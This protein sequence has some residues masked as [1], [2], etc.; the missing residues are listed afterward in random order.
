MD[1]TQLEECVSSPSS[2]QSNKEI[3]LTPAASDKTQAGVGASNG[4]G[5]S[6]VQ[7]VMVFAAKEEA[8]Q[9]AS[10]V[11]LEE[12][13]VESPS[14]GNGALLCEYPSCRAIKAHDRCKF[15]QYHKEKCSNKWWRQCKFEHCEMFR[16]GNTQF[17]KRHGGGRKCQ[18][19]GCTKL[20]RGRKYCASHGGG[21]RCIE[22]NCI[23]M[24]VGVS[25]RC[26]RHGG[27][28]RCHYEDCD[29][30][31]QFSWNFCARHA[32]EVRSTIKS[33]FKGLSDIM[34]KQFPDELN[35]SNEI[36]DK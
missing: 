31:A 35:N 17:C 21:K 11:R 36:K 1:I 26:L 22:P 23:R 15:C 13:N 7:G 33:N 34:L 5:T 6:N 24:A 30:A 29:K 32:S 18:V 20:A 19:D 8:K 9:T 3:E 16:Q 27:G 14:P 25:G 2:D 4:V 28:K 12:Q 10:G